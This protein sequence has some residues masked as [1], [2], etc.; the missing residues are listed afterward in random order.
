MPQIQ[1]AFLRDA[2]HVPI[3]TLGLTESKTITY[4][5]GTTGATGATTLFTV[6]GTVNMTVFAVCTSG[7]TGAAATLSAG[8]VGSVTSVIASTVGT[9]IATNAIWYGI[10][11]PLVGTA[12]A[13]LIVSSQ[14]IIQTIGVAAV[15]GG[16]LTYYC[17]WAPISADG[18]VV[19]A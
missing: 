10:T 1:S 11:P 15:T 5:A 13:N 4:V 7:L 12:P 9:T 14:N 2:N 8:V 16:S 6:T 17:L 3:T 19:A 18:N